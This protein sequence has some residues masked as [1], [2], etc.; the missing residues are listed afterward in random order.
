VQ[1]PQQHLMQGTSFALPAR[2]TPA[3]LMPAGHRRGSHFYITIRDKARPN[4]EL[5]VAP[6]ENPTQ[7]QVGG[8]ACRNLTTGR[9]CHYQQAATLAKQGTSKGC[10]AGVLAGLVLNTQC[11]LLSHVCL[12]A[13]ASAPQP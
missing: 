7:Q 1:G 12:L 3:A 13:G 11:A 9:H 6:V 2:F 5:L 8:G 4:S 10:G